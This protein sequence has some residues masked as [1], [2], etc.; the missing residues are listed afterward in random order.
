MIPAAWSRRR[1]IRW[2]EPR[3]PAR[4]GQ[5]PCDVLQRR[6]RVPA[7][8]R[9]LVAA[10]QVFRR[11]PE[12]NPQLRFASGR[13]FKNCHQSHRFLLRFRPRLAALCRCASTGG[14]HAASVRTATGE[15][16][17]FMACR[18]QDGAVLQ[19]TPKDERRG[20]TRRNEMTGQCK[21]WRARAG[22]I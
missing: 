8:R 17:P 21:N 2:R 4:A 11:H 12:Q 10:R 5:S 6:Q 1:C 18:D 7:L 16:E 9:S 22:Q 15:E 19:P 20:R 14:G 13:Q 3:L